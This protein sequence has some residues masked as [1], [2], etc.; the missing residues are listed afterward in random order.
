MNVIPSR[1]E[2]LP[3]NTTNVLGSRVLALL[4]SSDEEKE[5]NEVKEL[6][7]KKQLGRNL[8]LIRLTYIIRHNFIFLASGPSFKIKKKS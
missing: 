4:Q 3:P 2:T 8:F 6:N 7:G 1:Y 5:D